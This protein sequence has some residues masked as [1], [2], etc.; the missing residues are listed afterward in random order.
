MLQPNLQLITFRTAL[1][2]RFSGW[3]T[4]SCGFREIRHHFHFYRYRKLQ[5]TWQ[6]AQ[7]V[8]SKKKRA[9]CR[10]SVAIPNEHGHLKRLPSQLSNVKRP[11]DQP[12]AAPVLDAMVQKKSPVPPDHP[13][14]MACQ[15][16]QLSFKWWELVLETDDVWYQNLP[17]VTKGRVV[18]VYG[19]WRVGY[20]AMKGCFSL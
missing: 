6:L 5:L 13:F 14:S 2:F 12:S 18:A 19:P 7:H 15:I 4:K 16:S 11:F 9:I 8:F 20:P 1:W 3:H 10:V 17:P